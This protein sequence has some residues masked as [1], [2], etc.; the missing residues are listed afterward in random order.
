M[1][2][3]EGG[4]K[5]CSLKGGLVLD[6]LGGGSARSLT[7]YPRRGSDTGVVQSRAEDHTPHHYDPSCVT[8]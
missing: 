1:L 4:T 5:A 8:S 3:N 7:P 2:H 6:C